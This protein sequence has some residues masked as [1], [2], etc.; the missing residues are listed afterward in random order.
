MNMNQKKTEITEEYDKAYEKSIYYLSNRDYFEL[1][2]RNKLKRKD[3]SEG[4]IEY[5]ILSLKK[6]K[7][8]DDYKHGIEYAKNYLMKEGSIK[9]KSRLIERGINAEEANYIIEDA[10]VNE[11]EI[12]LKVL[13]QKYESISPC[14]INEKKTRDK[15]I[16]FLQRKGFEDRLVIKLLKNLNEQNLQ[17][18]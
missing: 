13:K 16:R 8:L 14:D 17:K 3:F 11:Y 6:N 10:E 18:T 9:V 12:G 7:Y 5:V 1:E 15:L 4:S 2:L